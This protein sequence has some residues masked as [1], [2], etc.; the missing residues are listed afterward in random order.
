MKNEKLYRYKL[1]DDGVGISF[2][3]FL[4]ALS[5]FPQTLDEITNE[6]H[7]MFPQKDWADLNG[8]IESF[9]TGLESAG[10]LVSG[11]DDLELKS[12]ESGK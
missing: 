8:E 5:F 6:V 2:V 4:K 10:F 9:I 3:M 1:G 12:K 7:K 11:Y